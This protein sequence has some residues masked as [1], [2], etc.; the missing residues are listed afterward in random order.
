MK[1]DSYKKTLETLPSARQLKW[2]RY[3]YYGMI[4]YGMNTM[5][6]AEWGNGYTPPDTFWPEQLDTDVWAAFAKQAGMS[7]LVLTAKHYDGFCLW[8]TEMTDYS[9][10]SCANW[11]DGKGD[12]VADLAASCRKAGLGFGLY[13]APWDKHAPTYGTGKPYDDFFC[14][15]LTELLTKYGDIF[16]IWLDPRV[17]AGVNGTMQDFDLIR[18]YTLIRSLQ[19]DCVIAGLGPDVRWNGGNKFVA[20][21]SEWS[22]VPARLYNGDKKLELQ[23]P[24]LGSRRVIRQDSDFM[25][26]PL[27]VSVPMRDGWFWKKDD[28]YSAKTKD[29]LWKLYLESVGHNANFMLG[30]CPDRQGKFHEVD[31]SI[32]KN[33]A[34]DLHL[35]FGYNLLTESGAVTPSSELSEVYGIQNVLHTGDGFWMP[36]AEEKR[37]YIDLHFEKPELFDKLTICENI[38]NGQRIEAFEVYIKDRK[39]KLRPAYL[40]ATVGNRQIC[41]LRTSESADIRI[42]FTEFR[43]TPQISYLAVN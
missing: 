40:G 7:A 41:P 32:L 31:T 26:Y 43:D 24:D 8:Q 4:A 19:P 34:K 37:P 30:I 13:V 2:Q 29:K 1:S 36:S 27:E 42:V 15:L 10:K 39:G 6:G 21:K 33:F 12:I 25:W 23:S 5:T 17:G 14:G 38:R 35:H 11:R 16:E 9:L 18:Y 22:V 3:G 28:S 20:R